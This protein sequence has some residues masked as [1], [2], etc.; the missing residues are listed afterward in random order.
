MQISA[1]CCA[2]CCSVLCFDFI[3]SHTEAIS[4]L[5]LIGRLNALRLLTTTSTAAEMPRRT[6]IGFIPAATALQ[7]AGGRKKG[8]GEGVSEFDGNAKL[9]DPSPSITRHD[10]VPSE[11][12]ARVS[13]AAVVVPSPAMSLVR[14]HT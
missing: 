14:L 8:W 3:T 1:L 5:E 4:S 6:S 11:R 9:I 12:I 10:T 2:V 7:P 13:T